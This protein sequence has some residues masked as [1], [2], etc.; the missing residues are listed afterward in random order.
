MFVSFHGDGST[1]F[2]CSECGAVS[3]R[4][5]LPC[6]CGGVATDPA[7]TAG[8]SLD[9]RHRG[10]LLGLERCQTCAGNVKIKIFACALHA[11]CSI[12]QGIDGVANCAACVDRSA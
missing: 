2:Y 3:Q 7:A 9:C 5:D 6:V 12:G 8:D 11:R 1:P 4:P 10:D